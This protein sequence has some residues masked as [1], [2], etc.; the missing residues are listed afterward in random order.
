MPGTSP[1]A[2]LISTT[3]DQTWMVVSEGQMSGLG[4]L[5]GCLGLLGGEWGGEESME[6]RQK[7]REKEEVGAVVR[8]VG[9]D[10]CGCWRCERERKRR[11]GWEGG[12]KGGRENG[13][14][15]SVVRWRR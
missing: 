11:C 3:K 10:R 1:T 2:R 8:R 13:G 14:G 12:E 6:E 4:G 5:S 7:G 9:E 15:W